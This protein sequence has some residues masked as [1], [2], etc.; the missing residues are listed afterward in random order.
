MNENI[1]A[2]L[3]TLGAT[4][5]AVQVGETDEYYSLKNAL[6]LNQTND[7]KGNVTV[8]FNPITIFE[9]ADFTKG[10]NCNL[11]KTAVMLVHGIRDDLAKNYSQAVSIITIENASSLV[12]L[13]GGK[14]K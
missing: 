5:L 4:I 9:S 3:T 13:T 7:G 11:N 12:G 8:G 10:M 6:F 2:Y 1:K 14:K